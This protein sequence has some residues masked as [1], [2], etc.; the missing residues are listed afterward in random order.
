MCLLS[1]IT[2]K[3]SSPVRSDDSAVAFTFS[4][5]VGGLGARRCIGFVC[6]VVG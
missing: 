6:E 1:S 3:F 2:L 5:T 4:A